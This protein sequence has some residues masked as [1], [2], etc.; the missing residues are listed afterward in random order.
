MLIYTRSEV[1]G[2]VYSVSR[3]SHTAHDPV[4]SD[5]IRLP[6][7]SETVYPHLSYNRKTDSKGKSQGWILSRTNLGPLSSMTRGRF[8][9]VRRRNAPQPLYVYEYSMFDDFRIA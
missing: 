5:K 2:V 9:Y 1:A 4:P 8:R 3:E 7:R 6:R